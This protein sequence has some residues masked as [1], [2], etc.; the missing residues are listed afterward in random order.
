MSFVNWKSSW[1]CW[2]LSSPAF[3][4]LAKIEKQTNKKIQK[5]SR[6]SKNERFI[7]SLFSRSW[8]MQT[9]SVR[10][11]HLGN[12][13][14]CSLYSSYDEFHISL[15]SNHFAPWLAP[16]RT[17]QIL[18]PALEYG[19]CLLLGRGGPTLSCSPQ[20]FLATGTSGSPS[21]VCVPKGS[22]LPLWK[23][24]EEGSD[25][26]LINTPSDKCLSWAESK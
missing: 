23:C 16:P 22:L 18:K 6:T 2:F 24:K 17:S 11:L 21:K 19:D 1:Y 14:S 9:F 26:V 8:K 3:P 10:I 4:S 7:C 5:Q 25:M 15:F 20:C 12:A 13:I